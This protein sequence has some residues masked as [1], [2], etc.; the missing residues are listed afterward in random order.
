[1]M[2]CYF[3]EE[4]RLQLQK[5]YPLWR[6]TLIADS[7]T[8]ITKGKD[9]TIVFYAYK[10]DY[11][12]IP[13]MIHKASKDVINWLSNKQRENNKLIDFGGQLLEV[14]NDMMERI[15]WG[16]CWFNHNF[17]KC[18]RKPITKCIT[19]K[20]I[21]DGEALCNVKIWQAWKVL[22]VE[23]LKYDDKHRSNDLISLTSMAMPT[24]I[25]IKN[26]NGCVS[27]CYRN[28]KNE[29]KTRTF[30]CEKLDAESMRGEI[31]TV[32]IDNMAQFVLVLADSY[33]RG[34]DLMGQDVLCGHEVIGKEEILR[35][36]S[37]ALKM[38]PKVE[39]KVVKKVEQ[40][41]VKKVEKKEDSKK[42][43]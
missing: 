16:T 17:I 37:E 43:Q 24:L 15:V 26:K 10:T 7:I 34:I 5:K 32:I 40:K 18:I 20:N 27:V 9:N 2:Q 23:W 12:M 6:Q 8:N 39:Q 13:V 33:K 3:G 38:K 11:S 35:S 21:S 28:S 19:Y 31:A 14:R 41:V 22:E 30:Y 36:L 4:G 42:K 25:S 1:M 29:W